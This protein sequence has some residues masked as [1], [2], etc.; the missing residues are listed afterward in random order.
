MKRTAT[1]ALSLLALFLCAQAQELN[2]VHE[3][4][5]V[6]QYNLA[7]IETLSFQLTAARDGERVADDIFRVHTQSGLAQF[8]VET[9]D[10]VCFTSERYMTVYQTGASTEFDLAEVDSL[11]FASTAAMTVQIGYDGTSASVV[12][13]LQADG[14]T[15]SVNGADVIVT[16]AAGLEGILYELSGSTTDGMFKIYS[17]SDFQLRL[18]GVSITNN[19]GPAIN[20]Q[21]DETIDVE[22][23]EGTSSIVTDGETYAE[24]PNDEDQ[25]G[26]FFSEGQLIFSGT[27]SLTVNGLGDDQHGLV[28]DDYVQVENGTIVVAS[29]SKDGIHTNEG[30]MQSG[31]SVDV[32]ADSDGVDAGDGPVEITGGSLVILIEDD[33]RDALK[34]DGELLIAGGDIE[35]SVDGDQ[36]KG[37]NAVTIELSGGVVEINTT[38]GAVLEESGS[39]YDPS[40]NTAVKADEQV[41]L[42]GTSLTINTTGAAARGISCD[43]DIL[44]ESGSLSVTSTG[45]G[46]TYTDET[47]TQDA[48]TGPCLKADGDIQLLGGTINLVH[49]GDGGK[50]ISGD[51]NL[52]IGTTGNAPVVDVH[53]SGGQI[54]IGWNDAAE[55][56]AI[57]MDS[58]ITVDSGIITLSSPDDAMKSKYWIEINGGLI[59]ITNSLEGIEAPMIYINGGEIQLNSTDDGINATMGSDIEG[60][61]GSELHITGGY[62]HLNA[63]QGD[64]IDSNGTLDI[65]GGTVLVHGPPNQ[66]EVGLDVNGTF[67]LDGGLVVVAQVNS[68][69]VES[70]SS[71]SSQRSVL[72]RRNQALSANTLFHIETSTGTSVVTF[73]PGHNYSCVLFSSEDLVQ[74]TTYRVY[75]GG[76]CTG[77][78][79]D[80]LYEGGSYSG[81][82]LRATFTLNSTVQSV[83]F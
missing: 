12:N 75:T 17:D 44:V 23:V 49:S 29:S 5:Q 36:S 45:D 41:L 57:S 11:S 39:G 70:P 59:D 13:P 10:S 4:G 18:N 43:G 65:T 60:D 68:M 74:G 66:P 38:G 53:T 73:K 40:Y 82:T 33:D 34:C 56:K 61:D 35:I 8:M 83:N 80:G 31:G 50:G 67:R 47:G 77:T 62:L 14:V 58:L 27:G 78:E 2:V 15:V 21:A 55:A 76:T 81:G 79:T 6:S 19:D 37:L 7:D 25:K 24:A 54:S 51:A 48:Y 42:N 52:S 46:G 22:L 1:L 26:A 20:I 16:A 69:M 3:N 9:V 32:T 30:Y 71:Q 64:G 28:S 72:C 63:P